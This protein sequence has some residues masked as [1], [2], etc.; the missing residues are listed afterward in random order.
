MIL[1]NLGSGNSSESDDSKESGYSGKNC[2][3]F[4]ILV[5]LVIM[6]FL[7][8]MILENLVI[9]VSIV[10]M[11]NIVIFANLIVLENLLLLVKLV[12][13][14]MLVSGESGNFVEYDKVSNQG[15]V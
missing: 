12:I 10:N 3:V 15:P 14:M 8:N 9:L 13:L 7:V 1:V 2:E 5:N 4:L 6:V 11:V